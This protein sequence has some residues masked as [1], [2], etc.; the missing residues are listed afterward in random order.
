MLPLSLTRRAP[1]F[2]YLVREKIA[3]NA[4]IAKWRKPGYENLCS[5]L[6]IQK[7]DTNFGTTSRAFVLLHLS[8]LA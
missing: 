3:D 5:L 1:Q 2:D 4:L 6:A 7:S 8:A